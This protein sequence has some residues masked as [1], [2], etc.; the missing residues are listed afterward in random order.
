MQSPFS[1]A[2]T[3]FAIIMTLS[4]SFLVGTA[5]LVSFLATVRAGEVIQIDASD[6][7]NTRTISTAVG[8]KLVPMRD[9]IDGAGGVAT[10]SA[11]ATFGAP[12]PHA[13]PD[14]G[15]FPATDKHPDI[16]MPYAKDDGASNQARRSA[17]GDA[18]VLSV[19]AKRYGKLFL[20]LSSGQGPSNLEI[21]LKYTD[22]TIETR[23]AVVPDWY[24][25]LKPDDKDWC[26]VATDLSK[27]GP[28]KMLE[29]SHHSIFG[30]DIHPNPGKV[31]EKILVSKADAGIMVFYGATGLTAD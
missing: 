10:A 29:K 1:P 15:K 8:G 19:P 14:D 18:Y 27:W 31:L 17:G 20:F 12:D 13:L 9:N 3:I 22:H 28:D 2:L 24:W 23:T 6:A 21:K 11:A 5:S 26:Y 4:R 30:L 16:V 7:F 25:D